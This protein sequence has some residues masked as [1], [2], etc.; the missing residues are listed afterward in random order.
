MTTPAQRLASQRNG[1]FGVI[2][3]TQNTGMRWA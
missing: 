2:S 1:S 3:P